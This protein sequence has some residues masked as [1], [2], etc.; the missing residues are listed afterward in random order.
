MSGPMAT[1]ETEEDLYLS[2]VHIEQQDE[3]NVDVKSI[4]IEFSLPEESRSKPLIVDQDGDFERTSA[5]SHRVLHIEHEME[6]SL[7]QVGLQLWRASLFL[8]DFVLNN[9]D[10]VKDRTVIELGT[11][12]GLVS[13]VASIYARLVFATDLKRIVKRAQANW[14]AN[15]DVLLLGDGEI[16]FKCLDWFAYETFL[17][18][19]KEESG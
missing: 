8:S 16:R 18:P 2:D 14:I 17:D 5:Q 9:V 13:F 7:S 19:A 3:Q 15:R 1:D 4:R 6:T 11:G 10:L 12:L